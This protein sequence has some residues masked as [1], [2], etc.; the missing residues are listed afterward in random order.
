MKGELGCQLSGKV[1]L[2]WSSSPVPT[3]LSI[4]SGN[5]DLC[6]VFRLLRGTYKATGDLAQATFPPCAWHAVPAPSLLNLP[7]MSQALACSSA[8]PCAIPLPCLLANSS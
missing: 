2:S 8:F 1:I 6:S 3:L 7:G 5:E 4:L